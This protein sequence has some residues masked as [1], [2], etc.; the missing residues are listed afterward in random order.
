MSGTE[1]TSISLPV[2]LAEYARQKGNASQ[3]IAGL[4]AQDRDRVE[5]A[6]RLRDMFERHGYTGDKAITDEGVA[7]MTDRLRDHQARRAAARGEQA[8]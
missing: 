8:A 5:R 7:R 1:R 3:Y 4:I 2:E 6:A